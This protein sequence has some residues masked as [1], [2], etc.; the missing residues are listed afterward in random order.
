MQDTEQPT[1]KYSKGA[2][3]DT[4]RH[5]N[6]SILY[7]HIAVMLFGLAGVAAQFVAV[8]AVITTLGRVICSSLLLLLIAI[9]KKDRLRLNSGRDVCLIIAAGAVM[10]VHW[11]TFFQSIQVSTVAIGTITFSAFPL[12]CRKL[13]Q[14]I[15]VLVIPVRKRDSKILL[16]QPVQP[17][18]SGDR[19]AVPRSGK[20]SSGNSE[21]TESEQLNM[22]SVS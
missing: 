12:F 20:T 11:T 7:L 4:R 6:K 13:C 10:A 8:S 5:F 3:M 17:A 1:R 9:I 21:K 2:F 19:K 16:G 22:A 18:V 15:M 14:H